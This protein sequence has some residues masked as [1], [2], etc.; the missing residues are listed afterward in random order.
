MKIELKKYERKYFF[1]FVFHNLNFKTLKKLGVFR[2]RFIASL[3]KRFIFGIKKESYLFM[4]LVD[5]KIVGGLDLTQLSGRTFNIRASIF[6][7]Y[8][9]MG[10]ATKAIRKLFIFAKK[11]GVK[12]ITGTNDKNNLASIKLVQKLGYKKVKENK[13]EIFWE[14]RL[15]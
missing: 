11:K 14:K 5:G 1:K 6:R 3:I 8:R 2:K 15:K 7:K 9:N 10:I 4:I 13:K 12:K